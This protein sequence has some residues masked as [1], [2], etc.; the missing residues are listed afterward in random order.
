GRLACQRYR[1]V[2]EALLTQTVAAT[3]ISPEKLSE[4]AALLRTLS[5]HYDQ[6][7]RAAASL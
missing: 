5:G 6:A 2:R 3:G 7:A 4:I 1:E